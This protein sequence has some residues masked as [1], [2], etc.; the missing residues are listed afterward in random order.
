[1]EGGGDI[2]KGI[3]ITFVDNF[4]AAWIKSANLIVGGQVHSLSVGTNLYTKTQVMNLVNYSADA[5]RGHLQ[6]GGSREL[7]V[8]EM[9]LAVTGQDGAAK[10]EGTPPPDFPE[11]ED[12]IKNW[13]FLKQS[14]SDFAES[15]LV[16]WSVDLAVDVFRT[17]R[18]WIAGVDVTLELHRNPASFVL[19]R[20]DLKFTNENT[21]VGVPEIDEVAK[22]ITGK[23]R[24]FMTKYYN[25][26]PYQYSLEDIVLHVRKVQ[27][28]SAVLS[29]I[30]TKLL[31]S[32]ALYPFQS[33]TANQTILPAGR[34]S[35]SSP[36]FWSGSV[37][38]KSL[39]CLMPLKA[40]TGD[41]SF[42]P[43]MF[44]H[45]GLAEF[46]QLING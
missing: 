22:R 4:G 39:Y 17:T 37:P 45:Y 1:M 35:Y 38:G 15:R 43:G 42:N 34:K 41:Y 25:D 18:D 13:S 46:E 7:M 2:P 5:R 19:L 14:Q 29:S 21:N 27:P 16:S 30:E 6:A 26:H 33:W 11:T 28:S 3:P 32:P 23:T 20:E 44:K 24:E 31:S 8:N 10:L 40:E 12:S 36:T 9:E